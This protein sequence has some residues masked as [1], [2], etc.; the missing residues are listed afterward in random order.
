M[1]KIRFRS[2]KT[3]FCNN[4]EDVSVVAHQGILEENNQFANLGL[5]IPGSE[6]SV[7]IESKK[8]SDLDGSLSEKSL[9]KAMVDGKWK[10][11][12]ERKKTSQSKTKGDGLFQSQTT[13]KE[14]A[15][16][17]DPGNTINKPFKVARRIP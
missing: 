14:V 16:I 1:D 5:L 17:T 3:S 8:F 10:V 9:L 11:A 4:F 6:S 15:K 7:D 12:M 2:S 13:Y